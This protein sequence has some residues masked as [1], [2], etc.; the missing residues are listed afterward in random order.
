MR[1]AVVV[2]PEARG[3][4]LLKVPG[5]QVVAGSLELGLDEA[6]ACDDVAVLVALDVVVGV[7][8]DVQ[9]L[10]ALEAKADRALVAARGESASISQPRLRGALA[11]TGP[12]RGL[13]E[14]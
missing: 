7:L 14:H 6:G 5:D 12:P 1:L 3:L 9:Q 13:R 10:A 2:V 4:A 8:E 11:G